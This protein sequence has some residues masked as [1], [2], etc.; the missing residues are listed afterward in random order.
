LGHAYQRMEFGRVGFADMEFFAREEDNLRRFETPI[1][2]ELGEFTRR[3]FHDTSNTLRMNNSTDWGIRV[4]TVYHVP[5]WV[6]LRIAG[7][8]PGITPIT[9]PIRRWSFQNM[10]TWTP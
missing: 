1:A 10:N 2:I 6:N 7:P 4:A 5:V 3:N 9:I 8:S